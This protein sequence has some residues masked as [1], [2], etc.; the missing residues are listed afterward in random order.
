MVSISGRK[1][2]YFKVYPLFLNARVSFAHLILRGEGKD[3]HESID[4]L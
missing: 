2:D 4:S 1:E 3:S